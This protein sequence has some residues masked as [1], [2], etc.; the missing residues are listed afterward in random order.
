[1]LHKFMCLLNRK[2]A[3]HVLIKKYGTVYSIL[4]FLK[5]LYQFRGKHLNLMDQFRIY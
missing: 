3:Y 5:L 2:S 4:M 1:M